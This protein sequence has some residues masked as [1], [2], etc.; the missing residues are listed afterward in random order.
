MAARLEGCSRPIGDGWVPGTLYDLGAYPGFVRSGDWAERVYGELLEL[1]NPE[2]AFEWLDEYEGPAYGREVVTFR[3]DEG[4][5]SEAW[6]YAYLGPV[7]EE[8]RIV[9]GVWP[10]PRNCV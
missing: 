4:T 1:S 10:I 2:A 9:S 5:R 6:C 3:S 7:R 8:K